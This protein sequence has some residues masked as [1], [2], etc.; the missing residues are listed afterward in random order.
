VRWSR[1]LSGLI[2]VAAVPS[3]AAG[4]ERL[5][6][7][8][9]LGVAIAPGIDYAGVSFAPSENARD[10]LGL[11]VEVDPTFGLG[12]DG[13]ELVLRLRLLQGS[14]GLGFGVGAS[15][16]AYFGRDEWKTYFQLGLKADNSPH[17][18]IGPAADFGVMYELSPWLGL[19]LQ[20]G[21]S[22]EVGRGLRFGAGAIIGLQGR[23]YVLE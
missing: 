13:N 17:L 1:C 12:T 11:V 20:P 2:L 14:P 18:A 22:V 23:T 4:Q 16:R 10:A 9:A 5:D 3:G 21:L 15:Y 7:R 6:H 8:G 19:F